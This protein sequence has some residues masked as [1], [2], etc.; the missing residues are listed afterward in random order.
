MSGKEFF[1]FLSCLCS[2]V[3][4]LAA[5]VFVI[6]LTALGTITVTEKA[7]QAVTGKPVEDQCVCKQ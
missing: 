2:S 6:A 5:I 7:Y 1:A 3:A 4:S